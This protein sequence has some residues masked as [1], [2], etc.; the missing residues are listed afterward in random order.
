MF[1]IEVNNR[2]IKA[3]SGETILQACK[4]ADIH[5]PTLCYME[6]LEP[7][8]A[9]RI[10]VVELEGRDGLVP[11]CAWPV[12]EDMQIKTHSARAVRA[13]KTNIELILADHPDDCLYCVRNGDCELQNMAEQ[14]GVRQRRYFGEKNEYDLDTSSPAISRDPSKC[15]LCGKCVRVCEE[16]QTVD[17]IEYVNR[18]FKATVGTAYD[19]GL[20]LSSCVYCGQCVRVCPT[21]ALREK[22]HIKEVM[23]AFNDPEKIVVAQ[24]APSISVTIGEEFG[25]RK[26]KDAVG[27]MNGALRRIGFN[28]VFTTSFSADL[29]I[30][31][32]A[33]E[34]VHRIQEGGKLPLITSCSPGWVKFMEQF[35]PDF[36][37]NVSSCKSPQ[38][39]MGAIIKTYFAE[40]EGIDP[41]NIFSV[42]MMP[43]T[44]KKFEAERPEHTKSG[45][46]DIDAVLTTRELARVIKLNGLDLNDM[47]PESHDTPFGERSSAGK[48]FGVSGGVMEAAVRTAYNMI[49]GE[50]LADPE[51]KDVRGLDG[52]KEAKIKINDDL[53]LGIAVA[54]G[55]KN[56]R[57]ILDQIQNGRN[58][59]H[60]IEV[61][62][63]PGGCINGG[64]QPLDMN[65]D[66][67]KARMKALYNIDRTDKIRRSH[68]NKSIQRIYKEFLG[69]PLS[70][71]SHELLHTTYKARKEVLT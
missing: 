36:A 52:V 34:L 45:R 60:F 41:E 3:K 47:E 8:G 57:K 69:E 9:C 32:E 28:R 18:G 63:C 7:S 27:I 5:I 37:E 13:R 66:T 6:G 50:E 61:M 23:E 64:G 40:K 2:K 12:Q 24:H 62:T 48:I 29:T 30:M 44:A 68:Q 46:P 22:S 31:E 49:T 20:N 55:L 15:I 58:D 71:K 43:C 67:L 11:A 4:R 17:A 33:A 10:C 65:E 59:I 39:M 42:S 21:G 19:E 56:A 26:G 35:Y 16:V 14:L 25:L 70:K 54:S 53:E 38:Q 1:T 51:L